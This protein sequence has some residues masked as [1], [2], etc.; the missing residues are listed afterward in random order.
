MRFLRIG[1]LMQR[2]RIHNRSNTDLILALEPE[3]D[4]F[5]LKQGSFA[6]F[7]TILSAVQPA[8]DVTIHSDED[9]VG[10]GVW[11]VERFVLKIDDKEMLSG[12]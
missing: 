3:G 12:E 5:Q 1:D 11:T 6:E 2:I 8:V 9:G 10:V 4:E 7:E